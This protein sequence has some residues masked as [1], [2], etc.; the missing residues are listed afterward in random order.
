M[1]NNQQLSAYNQGNQGTL[2]SN[3][4]NN[5]TSINQNT[6]TNNKITSGNIALLD[7]DNL[8]SDIRL[9]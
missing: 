5:Q 2:L 4:F 3:N 1:G 7:S 6:S 8:Q 9:L